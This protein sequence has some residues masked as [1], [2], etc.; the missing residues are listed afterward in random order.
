MKQIPDDKFKEYCLNANGHLYYYQRKRIYDTY[1]EAVIQAEK[2]TDDYE[3]K[4]LG[5]YIGE[6]LKRPWRDEDG[7]K[8]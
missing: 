4:G 8:K 5:K 6:K 3:Q 2:Q 7:R 1:S